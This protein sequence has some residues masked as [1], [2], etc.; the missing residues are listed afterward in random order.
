[1][2]NSLIQQ[3]TQF[4]NSP[5]R[6]RAF[7][8]VTVLLLSLLGFGSLIFWN[9]RPDYQIL[10][11]NLSPEDAGEMVNKLKERKLSYELSQNGTAILVPRDK[12]YEVRLS[13]AS[14]GLPKGGGVGFEVFDR[15]NLGTTDFVQRLNYQ[16][17][18][19]GELGR[20][21]K[22]MREI[23]Q[24]RVHIVTPRESLFVE[25]QKKATASVFI[26]TRSAM[27]LGPAQ[28]EGI[29]H[30][31]ASAVEGLE[32]VNITVV[33][34]SG[35]VLSKKNDTSLLGQLTSTQLEYQRNIEEGLKRKIQGMLEEV[36]GLN[37]AIARVSTEIDFQQVDITEEK[38][39]PNTVLRS[40]QKNAERSSTKAQGGQES[41]PKSQAQVPPP[42]PETNLSERQNET[43]NYEVSKIN[44][45]IKSPVG[46]VKRVSAAII[47]D[48]T[49]K[50]TPDSKGGRVKQYSP[51]QPD[52][53]KNLENIVKKAI[54]YDESRGDQIEVIQ[55]PF[56]WSLSE[57]EGPKEKT[58]RWREYLLIGYKPGVS[59]LLALLFI[60]FVVRPLLKRKLLAEQKETAL[61]MEPNQQNLPSGSS[62]APPPAVKALDAQGQ[63]LQLV[64]GDPSKAAAI[65]KAWL[66]EKEA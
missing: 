49:Y 52:E 40:E 65:V 60:F 23:E 35:R 63:T 7:L 50:E 17:A 42:P 53:M 13:L 56:S 2:Q 21:I 46:S 27:T 1:M 6:S 8:I 59:L 38:Y 44:R 47:V 31:I 15:T 36:L 18:L 3:L 66:R 12:V 57:E 25:E 5:S 34:T 30:L 14:E 26:K 64:H 55:M 9:N 61:L 16:R 43:R 4:L 58:D 22:Q 28:V 33:D 62:Q 48:G 32:P 41:N 29:V 54:G 10:F 37:K 19:Q 45:R 11:S 24:A 51:R 39:D 20:T